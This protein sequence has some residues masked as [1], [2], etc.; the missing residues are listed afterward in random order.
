MLFSATIHVVDWD[1]TCARLV[2]RFRVCL[3]HVLRA[4]RSAIHRC[5]LLN[6][7]ASLAGRELR[8]IERRQLSRTTSKVGQGLLHTSDTLSHCHLVVVM[9]IKLLL[10]NATLV[11]E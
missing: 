2:K 8:M 7:K 11:L 9:C 6:T 1:L 3:E 4:T 5:S 10:T